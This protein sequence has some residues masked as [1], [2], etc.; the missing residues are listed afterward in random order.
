MFRFYKV[1]L[2]EFN[3]DAASFQPGK[4][5]RR[6]K[7]L[8]FGWH[9]NEWVGKGLCGS[10]SGRPHINTG[11][12]A[13]ERHRTLAQ[14]PTVQSHAHACDTSTRVPFTC[15][16]WRSFWESCQN[17][18]ICVFTHAATSRSVHIGTGGVGIGACGQRTHATWPRACVRALS[19]TW[20]NSPFFFLP[21]VFVFFC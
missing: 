2:K 7:Q 17:V 14:R 3:M 13:R 8:S 4:F 6:N 19:P 1:L 20:L 21:Q 11:A 18:P 9:F 12:G 10:G 5:H 16:L 15:A